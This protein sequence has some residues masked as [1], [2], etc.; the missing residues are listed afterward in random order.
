MAFVKKTWKDGSEGGTPIVAVDLNRMEAGIQEAIDAAPSPYVLPAATASALGGVKLGHA[1]VQTVAA[2]A[3]SATA[4]RTYPVQ[5]NS[6]Q[7]MV[8]NVPWVQGATYTLP[9][10]TDS[11][12]GGVKLGSATAQTVAAAAVTATAARTYAVQANGS[13]QLVVNVPWVNTTYTLPAAT[14]AAIGGVKQGVAVADAVTNDDLIVQ[15]N[16]L[17]SSLRASGA[18][19]A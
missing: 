2:S 13:G 15:L 11:V 16:A 5:L 8:V 9:A 3:P 14:A 4:S 6:T 7:Q 18:L 17:L 10:A 1:T 19:A 12:L